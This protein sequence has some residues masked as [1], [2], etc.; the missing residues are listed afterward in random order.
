VAED[1]ASALAGYAYVAPF[2][3]RAGWRFVGEHSI[4][5]APAWQRRGVG[6]ALL[7]RLLAR[8]R[9]APL[10]ALVGVVSSHPASGAGAASLALHER[11]GFV[12]AGGFPR[13]GVKAGL[14]LDCELV[15]FALR[16]VAEVAAE[17][18]AAAAGARVHTN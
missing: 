18:A 12:R 4:Y 14:F 16:D 7:A 5:V 8:A 2:R 15:T 1:G 3:T 13:V 6:A 17:E 11:A 9:A 10:A